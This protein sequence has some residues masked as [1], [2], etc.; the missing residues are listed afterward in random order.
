[1][2]SISRKLTRGIGSPVLLGSLIL[3]SQLAIPLS[4]QMGGGMAGGAM[5]EKLAALKAST[6]ANQQRLHQYTWTETTQATLNGQAK[7]AREYTCMYGP[8]GKVVKTPIGSPAAAAP[9]SGGRGGAFKQRIIAKKTAEMKDYMTQVQG[10]LAMYVPPNPQRMQSAIEAKKVSLG[11]MGGA[12]T[13]QIV[14]KDYALPGDSMTIGYDTSA[15]K[16]RTLNVKTYLDNPQDGVTLAVQFAS[17]ADGT[18]Y[19]QQSTLNA[20]AKQLTAVTTSTNYRKTM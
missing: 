14:F 3:M 18:N 16:I 6:A 20:Q 17:L 9:A 13:A 1:M 7:P 2:N 19:V 4:A 5:Q 11:G 12:G 10:L 15:K 8:D